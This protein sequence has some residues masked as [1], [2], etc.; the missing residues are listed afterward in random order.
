SLTR[1]TIKKYFPKNS[2]F[3]LI[4]LLINVLRCVIFLFRDFLQINFRGGYFL[5]TQ[6]ILD[7]Q[8]RGSTSMGFLGKIVTKPMRC[9]ISLFVFYKIQIGLLDNIGD[10]FR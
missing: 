7:K 5:M 8:E 2:N 6:S 4:F 10:I 1:S 9:Y 3:F